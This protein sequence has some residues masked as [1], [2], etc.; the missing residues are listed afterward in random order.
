MSLASELIEAVRVGDADRVVQLV[1]AASEKERRAAA[2][3][4]NEATQRYRWRGGKPGKRRAASW[5]GSARQL[6]AR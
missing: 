4:V 3:K 5:R 2:E 6:R 1:A